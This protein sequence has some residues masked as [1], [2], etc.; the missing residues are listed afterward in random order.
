MEEE[1]YVIVPQKDIDNL[2]KCRVLLCDRLTP[3]E[4]SSAM[5]TPIWKITHRKYK[6]HSKKEV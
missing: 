4:I 6:Q 3:Y 2:E 1:K 5:I